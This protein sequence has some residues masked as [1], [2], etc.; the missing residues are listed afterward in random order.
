M[1]RFLVPVVLHFVPAIISWFFVVMAGVRM[2][3]EANHT[4]SGLASQ[5]AVFIGFYALVELLL[6]A[7]FRGL[8]REQPKW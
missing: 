5:A 7:E 1:R 8:K 3:T 6:G 4:V 2:L